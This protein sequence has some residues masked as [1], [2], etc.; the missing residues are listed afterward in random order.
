MKSNNKSSKDS[1]FWGM[2]FSIA[3]HAIVIGF[4]LFWGFKTATNLTGSEGP[5]QVSLSGIEEAGNNGSE[6]KPQVVR[7][8]PQPPPPGERSG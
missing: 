7:P 8:A 6:A 1:S 5:I 3:L 2:F 4:V